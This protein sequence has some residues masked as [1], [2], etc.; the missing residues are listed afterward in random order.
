[1]WANARLHCT[2]TAKHVGD[3][4]PDKDPLYLE[5]KK[6]MCWRMSMKWSWFY[7]LLSGSRSMLQGESVAYK[8][9][10]TDEYYFA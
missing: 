9:T 8:Q 6:W 4:N 3:R 10:S 2:G 5:N 1:M 7:R